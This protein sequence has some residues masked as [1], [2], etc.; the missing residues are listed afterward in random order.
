MH[1]LRSAPDCLCAPGLLSGCHLW[2]HFSS[3]LTVCPKNAS[4]SWPQPFKTLRPIVKRLR[5]CSSVSCFATHLAQTLLKTS[6]VNDFV[7]R[8]VTY[9]HI[10]SQFVGSHPSII[11]N[12]GRDPFNVL[13]TG[14]CGLQWHHRRHLSVRFY[15]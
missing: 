4:P 11:R 5:L 9:V 6:V 7:R 15:A 1:N 13:I 14:G 2:L 8:T 3:P 12:Y 10:M